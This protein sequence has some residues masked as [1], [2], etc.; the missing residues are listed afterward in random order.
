MLDSSKAAAQRQIHTGCLRQA[1][2][3]PVANSQNFQS[4][5]EFPT[6]SNSQP[7]VEIFSDRQRF[8]ESTHILETF[9]ADYDRRSEHVA[10][11]EELHEYSSTCRC[12]DTREVRPR[13]GS[14]SAR[15]AVRVDESDA[16]ILLQ[17]FDGALQ[18]VGQPF[19]IRVE[20]SHVRAIG[21]TNSMI[22]GS[23]LPRVRLTDADSA[24]VIRS[25]E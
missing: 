25:E 1:A 22:A 3:P 2:R 20:K 17:D 13:E 23:S 14:G 6:R 24:F 15:Q 18:L 5:R 4:D 7:Q 11:V 10:I 8:T 19:V 12:T 16:R 21:Q 9:P